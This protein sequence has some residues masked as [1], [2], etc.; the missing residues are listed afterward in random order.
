MAREITGKAVIYTNEGVKVIDAEVRRKA[1]AHA[2]YCIA[3]FRY[4]DD[5]LLVGAARTVP[6]DNIFA[7]PAFN[8]DRVQAAVNYAESKFFRLILDL[9]RLAQWN[10]INKANV[11]LNYQVFKHNFFYNSDKITV[12]FSKRGYELDCQLYKFYGFSQAMID[13]VEARYQ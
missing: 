2:D 6:T 10:P 3:K 4:P 12:D 13:F 7:K 9:M 1:N 11:V 5:Y 8:P